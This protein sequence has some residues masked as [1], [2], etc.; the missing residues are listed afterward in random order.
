MPSEGTMKQEKVKRE[1]KYFLIFPIFLGLG[2]GVGA[3]IRNVGLGLAIG[4]AV[5]TPLALLAEYYL[6]RN[7]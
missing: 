2:T 7:S 6:G 5:G 4:A 3:L 1:N